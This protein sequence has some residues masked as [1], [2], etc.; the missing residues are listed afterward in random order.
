MDVAVA[1][2]SFTLLMIRPV[3]PLWLLIGGGI[4]RLACHWLANV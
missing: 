3:G 1:V 4:V 2:V